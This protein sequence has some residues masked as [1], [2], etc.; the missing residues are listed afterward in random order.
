MDDMPIDFSRPKY[1]LDI[2]PP[3]MNAAGSLGFAPEPSGLVN[4]SQLGAFI[5]NPISLQR[6]T[7]ANSRTCQAY[8]G[9]LLLHSGYPNPGLRTAI[10]RY[11]QRWAR[12]S[13]PII[14]H[15]LVDR[16]ESVTEMII[17][18]EE[19]EGVM[20]IELGLPPDINPEK[21]V[22]LVQAAVGELPLIVRVPVERA[23]EIAGSLAESPLAA[24]SLAPPRGALVGS[25]GELVR[26]RLFGPAVFP[27]ALAAVQGTVESG[28]PVIAAGGIYESW[29]VEAYLEAGASAV[30]LDAVLWSLG[31]QGV[32]R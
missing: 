8:P 4:F 18:L 24:I 14:V 13:T 27:V 17:Q 21:A 16:K 31:W 9:G 20:G 10:R 26:G 2:S 15:L 11:A 28:V 23:G 22:D 7:P 3:L 30:Q 5:T 12:S 29:Q 25:Q 1:D 19:L 32:G 6:R